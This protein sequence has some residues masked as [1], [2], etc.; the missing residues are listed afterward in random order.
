MV[1]KI[2]FAA[3]GSEN[4]FNALKRWLVENPLDSSSELHLL[5]V[6]LPVDG[7]VRSFVNA[8]A[9]SDYHREE[10]LNA[11]SP[12]RQWFAISRSWD[13]PLP[14]LCRFQPGAMQR[15]SATP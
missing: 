3:D 14:S 5:N 4:A 13:K 2:L 11:L 9:I 10:R 1:R 7:N 15:L 6:Q 8:D 12:A